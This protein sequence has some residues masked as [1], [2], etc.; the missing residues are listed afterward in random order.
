MFG[1]HPAGCTQDAGSDPALRE[2]ELVG[3]DEDIDTYMQREV[4]P[5]VEDAWVDDPQGREGYE[6]PFTRLFYRYRPPRTLEE[7]DRDLQHVEQDIQRMLDE[8]T[9]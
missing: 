3:L 6:V 8:V 9:E 1:A 5:F 7:V 4:S 2:Y